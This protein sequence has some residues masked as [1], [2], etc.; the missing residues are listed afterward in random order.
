M[1]FIF[2]VVWFMPFP[3][4]FL[5][6]KAANFAA[7]PRGVGRMMNI[8]KRLRPNFLTKTYAGIE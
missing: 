7:G 2:S 4:K 3:K 8:F 6:Q 1:K 5:L